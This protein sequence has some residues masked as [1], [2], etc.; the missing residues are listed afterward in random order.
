LRNLLA[1]LGFADLEG[2]INQ[3]F[4]KEYQ[5]QES[6]GSEAA[7]GLLQRLPTIIRSEGGKSGYSPVYGN[8]KERLKIQGSNY[9]RIDLTAFR[10]ALD[11]M[12]GASDLL[13][14]DVGSAGGDVTIDRFGEFEEFRHIIGVDLH[15]GRVADANAAA[16]NHGGKFSFHAADIEAPDFE[17]KMK[18]LLRSHGKSHF[19]FIFSALTLHH[20]A[21]PLKALFKLRKLLAS[22][23]C[24]VLRGSDDGSK[25]AYPDEQHLVKTMIWLTQQVEGASDRENGRKLYHQLWKTGFRRIETLYDVIDTAGLSID[26]RMA[27]FQGSFS[28]RIHNFRKRLERDPGNEMYEA[29]Y[30]WM[31]EAL[32]ELE[33]QFA[34][35]SFL[36]QETLYVAIARK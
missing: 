17:D 25:L 3:S 7:A 4:K 31:R 1:V 33:I 35:D 26:Q 18:E 28:Y 5:A 13:A 22:G 16:A 23:G 24:I 36:Y 32:E 34:D 30:N 19:D 27:L 21:S 10:Q 2:S 8:E 20:L 15:E 6:D 29:E 12:N 9:R 11:G 14:L